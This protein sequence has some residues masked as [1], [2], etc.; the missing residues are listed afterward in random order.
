LTLAVVVNCVAMIQDIRAKATMP[1]GID[2]ENLIVVEALPFGEEYADDSFIDQLLMD[3]LAVLRALPGVRHAMATSAIPVS[4]SGSSTGRRAAGKEMLSLSAPYFVVSD[5]AVAT[6][7]IEIEEGRDFVAEDF[8][9]PARPGSDPQIMP[10]DANP[11]QNVLVTRDLADALFPEGGALGGQITSGRDDD[12]VDTI[13]GIIRRM[14]SSWPDS[15]VRKRVMLFPGRPGNERT[16]RY[17]VRSDPGRIE[18]VYPALEAALLAV[19]PNRIIQLE[20][21]REVVDETF[22]T[23]AAMAT[24]LG[25]VIGL[26][27]VVTAL[28]IVGLTSFSVTER[29]RQIG[30]RRAL[31]ATRVAILRWFLVENWLI[32]GVGLT[33]GVGLTWGVNMLIAQFLELERLPWSLVFAGMLALWIVGLAAALVPALRGTFVSPVVATRSV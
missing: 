9:P 2:V 27:V 32:T 11:P 15:A 3:D 13:V 5:G 1:T 19:E 16:I 23:Q 12:R 25:T 10:A 18:S 6:L 33:L 29:T 21:H 30:T 8:P 20:T 17:M 26:L 7:G 22:Q 24:M 14:D 28:G 4:G 31:G